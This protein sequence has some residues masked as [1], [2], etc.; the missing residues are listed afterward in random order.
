MSAFNQRVAKLGV[1]AGLLGCASAALLAIGAANASA[2]CVQNNLDIQGMGSSLQRAAQTLWTGREVPSGTPLQEIPHKPE[3]GGYATKCPAELNDA[4]VSY[5]STSS[6]H[7]LNAFGFTGGPLETQGEA[8]AFIGTDDAPTKKQNENAEKAAG[9]KPVIVPVAQTAIAVI[10]NLP[11]NCEIEGGITYKDLNKLFNGTLKEWIGLETDNGNSACKAEIT[12]VV[13]AEGSGT[14]YQ[15]KNYLGLL[16]ESFGAAGPGCTLKPWKELREIGTGEE[17]NITWPKCVGTTPL[18]TA[19]GGGGGVA[20]KVAETENTIGYAALPD[21]KAKGAD[22]VSLQ[23]ANS[24]GK[25]GA[26]EEAGKEVANCGSRSYV[27][28]PGAREIGGTGIAVD[29]SGVFG[30]APTVGGG[31]YPLCALTY[32]IGWNETKAAGYAGGTG[33]V[34]KEYLAY[35]LGEGQTAIN[36]HYYAKLPN[37]EA[38]ANDVLKAAEFSRTKIGE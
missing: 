36:S 4:T 25:Y 24:V 12:R 35:V 27:V 34:V 26:P 9:T 18:V 29:W 16:E 17:P 1:C 3:E 15:F 5:T 7:G 23:D 33:E 19:V 13:R 11:A 8:V 6:G 2:T 37:P 38:E 31:S 14:T 30:A 21:A 32:D 10:A 20:E 22:V 28:P